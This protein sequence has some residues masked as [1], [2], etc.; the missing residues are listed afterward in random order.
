MGVFP[1]NGDLFCKICYQEILAICQIGE[2]SRGAEYDVR[3]RPVGLGCPQMHVVPLHEREAR[4]PP[5]RLA[6]SA[7][8]YEIRLRDGSEPQSGE[9]L[10][11]DI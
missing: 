9:G 3:P 2:G 7:A 4:C 10:T 5:C 6:H 8:G 1:A 11:A